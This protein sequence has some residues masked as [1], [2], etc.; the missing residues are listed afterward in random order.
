[1]EGTYRVWMEETAAGTAQVCRSGLYYEV[2]CRC[3]AL[4]EGMWELVA[5]SESGRSVLGLL[6]PGHGGME[7]LRRIP[8]KQLGGR[9]IRFCLRRRG[10]E[11][12][13]QIPVK[14][15]SPFPRLQDLGQAYLVARGR[16]AFKNFR[17]KGENGA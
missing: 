13:S 9:Q 5:D 12:A 16:I 1:M 14:S 6:A 15:G 3:A 4:P 8:V 10:V 2:R 7:L 17:E 11:A